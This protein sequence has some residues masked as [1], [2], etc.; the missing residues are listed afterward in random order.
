MPAFNSLG[1]VALKVR[2]LDAAIAFYSKLGFPE[3]L[4]LTEE[5]GAPWIVYMRVTDE[6]FIELFPGGT[7]DPV[8]DRNAVGVNHLS[9]TVDDLDA[10]AAHL[11]R[12]GIAFSQPLRK[13]RGL[14]KNRGAWIEDPDGNRIEIMEMASDCIQYEAIA[15]FHAGK[16]PHSLVRPLKP[17]P[18]RETSKARS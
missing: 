12:V 2:D 9:L 3:F 17:R 11:A 16:P 13:E 1:H 6:L 10:T 5:D 7:G 15:N 18:G 14:D 4:R 8:A